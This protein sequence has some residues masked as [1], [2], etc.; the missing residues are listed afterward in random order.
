MNRQKLHRFEGPEIDMYFGLYVVY[1]QTQQM[2]KNALW[3]QCGKE[4]LFS[5][6]FGN[7]KAIS[8]RISPK[9]VKYL[10]IKKEF[11]NKKITL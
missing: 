8:S 9:Y 7:R 2:I 1:N 11:Q 3:N 10:N 4:S 5:T 6:Q